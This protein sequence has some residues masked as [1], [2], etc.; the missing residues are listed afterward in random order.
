MSKLAAAFV[1][2]IYAASALAADAP[3]SAAAGQ[4][5]VFS[6]VDRLFAETIGG[7]HDHAVQ[8]RVA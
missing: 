4:P 5:A 3:S 6:A 2:L 8:D 7:C 1:L